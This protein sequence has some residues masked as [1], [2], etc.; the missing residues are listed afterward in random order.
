[1]ESILIQGGASLFGEICVS[2]AKNAALPILA[3]C[4][5]SEECLRLRNIPDLTDIQTMIDLLSGHGVQIQRRDDQLELIASDI[6]NLVADYEIVRKMRASIWVLAPLLA[7]FGYAKV[8]MPGGCTIGTRQVDMHLQ[9]LEAMGAKIEVDDGYIT[10]SSKQLQGVNFIFN[11]I[12][13]GAT[14]SGILASVLAKGHTTLLNCA[15]EPEIIDLCNCLQNRGA[16]I[17]GIGSTK[18]MIEG[19]DEFNAS[20]HSIIPDRIEAGTYMIAAAITKGNLL[21]KN[22][23]YSHVESLI[24]KLASCGVE[25]TQENEGIR[26]RY[27][28]QLNAT[29]ISTDVFPGFPTDLQAQFTSLMTLARGTCIIT[30]NIFENRFMHVP[31]LLRMNAN[32]VI[33]GNSL[34]IH[35]VNELHGARVKASDL[36]A[37]A[38]LVLAGLAAR[39]DTCIEKIHHLDRGYE[40]LERKLMQCGAQIER[41]FNN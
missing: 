37:S 7:R 31:E 8:S 9:L 26:V 27:V 35:G 36:R 15:I 20:E 5:L 19:I 17:K 22:I 24:M 38:C 34:T 25:I 11:K 33:N 21:I 6:V 28:D 32:I 18:L 1:M 41:I 23:V 12:S 14:V 3:S 39:G 30:E 4:L 16:K 29:N 13:V 2:G 40:K 10:A